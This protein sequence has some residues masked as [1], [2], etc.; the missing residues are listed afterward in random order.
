MHREQL[1]SPPTSEGL[2]LMKTCSKKS[3]AAVEENCWLRKEDCPRSRRL[4][5]KGGTR[6]KEDE[7]WSEV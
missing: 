7:Q 1:P 4:K 5:E 2:L 3:F 6:V